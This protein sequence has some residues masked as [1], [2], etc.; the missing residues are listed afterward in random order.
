MLSRGK[1]VLKGLIGPLIE[2]PAA[3]VDRCGQYER[4]MS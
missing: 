3:R 1:N 4:G 2:L